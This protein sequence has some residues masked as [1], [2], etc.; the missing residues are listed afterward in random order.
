[1]KV[2]FKVRHNIVKNCHPWGCQQLVINQIEKASSKPKHDGPKKVLIIGASSGYGLGTRIAAAFGGGADTIG[3]SFEHGPYPDKEFV[4]SAG[5]YNN[6]FFKEE[7]EKAGLIAK[8]FVGDAFSDDMRKQVIN[9]IQKEFGGK[10]DLVVYSIASGKRRTPD[11]VMHTSSIGA[12]GEPYVGHTFDIA[13]NSMVEVTAPAASQEQIDETVTVMGGEDWILWM[14]AL[15]AA[16][17]LAQGCKT[18]AYSYIG[19]DVTYRIYTGGTLGRAKLHLAETAELINKHMKQDLAGNAYIVVCKAMVTK[20]M[21]FI[22]ASPIY[23]TA[24][25]KVMK[26]KNLNEDIVDQAQRIF[27]E[28]L[29]PA[30][31]DPLVDENRWIRVDD[32]E[33]RKDVQTEVTEL[34]NAIKP[35]NFKEVGDYDQFL[36][37]FRQLNGFDIEGVDYDKEIDWDAGRSE[38]LTKEYSEQNLR[39]PLRRALIICVVAPFEEAAG[40]LLAAAGIGQK[41]RQ[42][43]VESKESVADWVGFC[44]EGQCQRRFDIR[45]RG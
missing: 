41:S 45:L 34:F 36:L 31:G 37:D 44:N 33:M 18:I 13:S 14:E 27:F 21:V 32:W 9:F 30:K 42:S 16:G 35:D 43:R 39:R 15:N 11:G 8:N 6:I 40:F 1:M 17:V 22:P 2:E 29:Y 5:W 25:I 3:V 28:K 24:L 20:A 7:A 12:I 4:G 38:T 10:V 23:G 19:P 26:E